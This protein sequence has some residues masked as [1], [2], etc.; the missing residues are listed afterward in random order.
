MG[1]HFAFRP[2][3]RLSKK[4]KKEKSKHDHHWKRSFENCS[5]HVPTSSRS[6]LLS[7]PLKTHAIFGTSNL[8]QT[9]FSPSA[10]LSP[11]DKSADASATFAYVHSSF[12]ASSSPRAARV[13]HRDCL[14]LVRRPLENPDENDPDRTRRPARSEP[15]RGVPRKRQKTEE[16]VSVGGP[17]ASCS[18]TQWKST[19]DFSTALAVPPSTFETKKWRKK[20]INPPS[21]GPRWMRTT[22]LS[23]TFSGRSGSG[24]LREW[25]PHTQMLERFA[26]APLLWHGMPLWFSLALEFASWRGITHRA[27]GSPLPFAKPESPRWLISPVSSTPARCQWRRRVVSF[28]QSRD[29]LPSTPDS[30]IT[31][32]WWPTRSEARWSL[33]TILVRRVLIK[34]GQRSPQ[35]IRIRVGRKCRTWLQALSQLSR[36][37]DRTG[38]R[39]WRRRD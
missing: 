23:L 26:F 5:Y 2:D 10:R 14:P 28:G 6:T 31:V 11:L 20:N 38:C 39:I 16:A 36:T 27:E 3:F 4:K 9:G 33:R 21:S 19:P 18:R 13:P 17:K 35:T 8:P 12:R 37:F 30:W 22:V 34:R 1:D 24:D 32:R 25:P 29:K 7:L 15:G